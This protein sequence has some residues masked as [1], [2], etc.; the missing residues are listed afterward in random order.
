MSI[1]TQTDTLLSVENLQTHFYTDRGVVKAVEDVSFTIPRGKTLGVVGESGSGKSVTAM[2]IMRLISHP[3]RIA[4]GKITLQTRD[5]GPLVLNELSE[6]KMRKVRGARIAMIFQE[7][8]TSLNPVFTVG[9][10]IAEAVR[11][12]Q[13]VSHS[14]ARKRAIEM[15]DRVRI[16]SPHSRV[17]DYPHQFSGGMR[18]RAMIAMALSCQPDLLIA[19]EPT[20]ALDVTIQAQILELLKELQEDLGMSIM[21]ITHDLGIIAETAH[22]VVVMYA[23]KVVERAPVEELFADPLHPYTMGL[24]ASRP[25][26][27]MKRTDKLTQIEGNVPSPLN[28]PRGCK[29]HPRCPFCQDICRRDE[30]ELREIRPG[31]WS[32]C[33][34]S[35]E[36]PQ[37]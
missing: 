12:H 35:G 19:D 24:F 3:G 9:N 16:P 32:R 11:L 23:S 21:I 13:N 22:E 2:S 10:Q 34:F 7:P 37:P 6:S 27:G 29:F 18:Q 8:M 26:P 1:A 28:F 30:P 31:H 5:Q 20:T 4:G 33:H 17:D 15:L 36:L 25:R 14:E